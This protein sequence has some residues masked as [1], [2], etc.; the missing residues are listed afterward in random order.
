[1]FIER[2]DAGDAKKILQFVKKTRLI[3]TGKIDCRGSHSLLPFWRAD[4]RNEDDRR[5]RFSIYP[6]VG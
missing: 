5:K 1:M 2:A 3:I 4:A 6:N